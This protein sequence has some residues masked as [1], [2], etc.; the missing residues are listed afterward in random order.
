MEVVQSP[1]R[2]AFQQSPAS[3]CFR[4]AALAFIAALPV[5][6]NGCFGAPAI[7]PGR[8]VRACD[9]SSLVALPLRRLIYVKQ[10]D[11]SVSPTSS[12]PSRPQRQKQGTHCVRLGLL[13]TG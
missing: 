5:V 13:N 11:V 7:V 2:K 9:P 12:E 3:V 8:R 10:R 6:F 4:K 1:G